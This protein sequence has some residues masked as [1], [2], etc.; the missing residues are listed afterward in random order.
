MEDHLVNGLE[1]CHGGYIFSLADTAMAFASNSANI[2]NLAQSAQITFLAPARLGDRLT[3]I[4]TETARAGRNGIYD[5]AVRNQTGV[6]I[7]VFRGQ[8]RAIKG[9]V[10]PQ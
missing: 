9:E 4:A 1:V 10:A 5:V 2:P 7:A 8:T 3:A 6:L